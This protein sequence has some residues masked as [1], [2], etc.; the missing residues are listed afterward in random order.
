VTFRTVPDIVRKGA[1]SIARSS[2]DGLWNASQIFPPDSESLELML[3]SLLDAA[4]VGRMTGEVTAVDGLD[5][6]ACA[7]YISL[8]AATDLFKERDGAFAVFGRSESSDR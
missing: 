1:G 6:S 4:E 3:R 7:S 5:L 8:N 2:M